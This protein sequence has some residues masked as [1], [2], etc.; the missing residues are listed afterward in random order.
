MANAIYELIMI[1]KITIPI[2]HELLL[3]ALLF[4]N[5]GTNTFDFK[6]GHMTPT[7]LDMAQVFGLK[8]SGR[9]VDITHDWSSPSR[10]VVEGSNAFQSLLAWSTTLPHAR[11][12]R[13]PS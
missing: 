6:V 13:F 11:A 8:P 10:L 7:I 9:C 12:M 4:R 3:T 2:K 1:S 5:T